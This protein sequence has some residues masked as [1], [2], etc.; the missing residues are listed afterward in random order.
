MNE[1]IEVTSADM[2]AAAIERTGTSRMAAVVQGVHYRAPLTTLARVNAMA[3]RAGKSRNSM[4]TMLLN[5]G[6]EQ[7]QL[8]LGKKVAREVS[9]MEVEELSELMAGQNESIEE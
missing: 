8:S 3:K 5:V 4:M 1:V 9:K 2:V 7:V 6:L